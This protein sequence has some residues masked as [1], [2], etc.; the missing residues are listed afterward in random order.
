MKR[1]G[2]KKFF[3]NCLSYQK[4]RHVKGLGE[5]TRAGERRE[6]Q[7][8]WVIKALLIAAAL[9]MCSKAL[10]WPQAEQGHK[11]N[12]VAGKGEGCLEIFGWLCYLALLGGGQL[13]GQILASPQEVGSMFWLLGNHSTLLP[14]S[15]TCKAVVVGKI[16]PGFHS[17]C[18]VSPRALNSGRRIIF[19]YSGVNFNEAIWILW[20]VWVGGHRKWPQYIDSRFCPLLFP[21]M[22][23]KGCRWGSWVFF[24][25]HHYECESLWIETLKTSQFL[26]KK[27]A[28]STQTHMTLE[29]SAVTLA[30]RQSQ[31][32]CHH[33]LILALNLLSDCRMFSL[34][35][36]C[37]DLQPT[38]GPGI[39]VTW[40]LSWSLFGKYTDL[41]FVLIFQQPGWSEVFENFG[42]EK[43]PVSHLFPVPFFST[44][45][46][47]SC[48]TDQAHT[49]PGQILPA[50]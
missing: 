47:P 19:I 43:D 45:S 13:D 3:L 42:V 20:C 11:W 28:F 50:K 22:S 27:E 44:S 17:T 30:L 41:S 32:G 31:R 33:S 34:P 8:S 14:T 18:K 12:A 9:E 5:G 10:S 40:F 21:Y 38:L 48:A 26:A 7:L 25:A 37:A 2:E 29:I 49:A 4:R 6:G 46:S 23:P 36:G 39:H 35:F 1:E 24:L 16:K 15:Q